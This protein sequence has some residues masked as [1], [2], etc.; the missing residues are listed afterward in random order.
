VRVKDSLRKSNMKIGNRPKTIEEAVEG[1]RYWSLAIGR[2]A[3]PQHYL[4]DGWRAFE[5][6]IFKPYKQELEGAAYPFSFR[7]AFAYWLPFYKV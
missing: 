3:S 6:I 4:N 1:K 2:N 5:F 7:F